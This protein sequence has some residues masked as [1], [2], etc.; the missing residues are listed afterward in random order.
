MTSFALEQIRQRL[1]NSRELEKDY[2][3]RSQSWQRKGD[4]WSAGFCFGVAASLGLER[5]YLGRIYK[6]VRE[7]GKER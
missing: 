2:H 7:A 5:L 1:R 3:L 6:W 4:D